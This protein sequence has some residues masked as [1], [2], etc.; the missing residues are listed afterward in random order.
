MTPNVS[1][2]NQVPGKFRRAP[3]LPGPGTVKRKTRRFDIREGR[4]GEFKKGSRRRKEA[5]FGTKNTSAA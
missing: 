4:D 1:K 2:H 5:D 3:Y